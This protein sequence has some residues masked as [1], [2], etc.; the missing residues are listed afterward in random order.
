MENLSMCYRVICVTT[1][2]FCSIHFNIEYPFIFFMKYVFNKS[3]S[4]FLIHLDSIIN[5]YNPYDLNEK[6][7]YDLSN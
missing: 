6:N 7:V 1:H 5:I 4:F 3:Y 2:W